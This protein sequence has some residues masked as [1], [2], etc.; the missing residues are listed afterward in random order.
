LNDLEA[1]LTKVMP[2]EF[3]D[4]G[5]ADAGSI[6]DAILKSM[7]GAVPEEA[8]SRSRDEIMRRLGSA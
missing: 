1:A 8:A 7:A 6:C 4:R 2:G 3:E 5:C